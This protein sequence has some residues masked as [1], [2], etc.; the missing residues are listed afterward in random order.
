MSLLV[1]DALRGLAALYVMVSHARWFLWATHKEYLESGQHG[2]GTVFATLSASLDY[3]HH[4]VLLF[5]LLSGFCIHYRQAKLLSTANESLKNRKLL[6]IR[7]FAW[8]RIKRLYP[9]LLV[10]LVLTTI[11]DYVG[12]QINPG[13]YAGQTAYQ[14]LNTLARPDFSIPTVIGNLFMQGGLI[15]PPLGNN[16]PLWSLAWEFWFYALYPAVLVLS[17]RLRTLGMLAVVGVVSVATFVVGESGVPLPQWIVTVLTYWVY[18]PR[19]RQLLRRTLGE[20]GCR[21]CVF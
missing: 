20:F 8:R 1:L 21:V 6:D 10:A 7:S 9:A 17:T 2:V 15:V 16:A 13:F 18:G 3:S 12:L 5:F 19:V 4:A 11:L 14:G